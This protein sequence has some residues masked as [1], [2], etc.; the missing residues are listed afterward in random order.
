MALSKRYRYLMTSRGKT[1][2]PLLRSLAAVMLL[3]WVGAVTV[4]SMKCSC[5][6]CDSEHIAQAPTATSHS[7][8][9]QDQDK[10]CDHDG[11]FCHSL[12]SVTPVPAVAASIKPSFGLTFT[13]NFLSTARL[14]A[15]APS[16][17][18]ISRQ[19]ADRNRVFT[20]E[21]CLGPAFRTLAP[22]VPA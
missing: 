5:A 1:Y 7:H 18:P 19:P 6:G 9:S 14:V 16:E 8:N 13:L 21:V 4:C 10:D 17:T 15:V 11:S 3:V 20:P 22:P 12:H 2:S